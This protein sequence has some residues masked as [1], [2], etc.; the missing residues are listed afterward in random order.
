MHNDKIRLEPGEKIEDLQNGFAII[1]NPAYFAFGTDA[2]LLAHFA[3]ATDGERVVDFGTGCG[4]IPIL[5]CARTCRTHFTG[6]DIQQP[7]ADMAHRSVALNALESRVDIVCGDIRNVREIVAYGVDAVVANPPYEKA[8]AGKENANPYVNIAKREV[9]CELADIAASTAK[10]LRTGGRLYMIY[11]TARFAELMATLRHHKLEP[12]RIQMVAPH[13]DA[14]PNFA[15]V[16][17]RKGAGEGVVFEPTLVI[18]H[19]DGSY[20]APLKAIYGIQED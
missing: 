11:R 7:L 19:K 2:V 5:M 16:E 8:G 13:V 10:V 17:A 3:Q 15:L 14:A 6:I 4:I 18:Y 12:K 1:Q 9:C 20:T